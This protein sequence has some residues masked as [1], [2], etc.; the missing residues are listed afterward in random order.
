MFSDIIEVKNHDFLI[1]NKLPV[2]FFQSINLFKTSV[3]SAYGPVSPPG[4]NHK[5]QDVMTIWVPIRL[6]KEKCIFT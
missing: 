5:Q 1:R 2:E 3:L 4:E 6:T